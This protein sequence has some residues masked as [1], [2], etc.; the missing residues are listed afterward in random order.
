MNDAQKEAVMRAAWEIMADA[1]W[2]P[3]RAGRAAAYDKMRE[4][5]ND[6]TMRP[7]GPHGLS[8]SLGR[9]TSTP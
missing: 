3:G 5:F 6:D 9:D 1:E 8:T 4:L 7:E 2:G